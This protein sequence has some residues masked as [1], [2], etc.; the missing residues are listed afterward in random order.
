LLLAILTA[1][2]TLSMSACF[3]L[4]LVE[5]LNMATTGSALTNAL[6]VAAVLTAMEAS[7][8]GDGFWFSAQSAKA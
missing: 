1:S 5:W 8:S 3:A 6:N 4:P 7:S 2:V